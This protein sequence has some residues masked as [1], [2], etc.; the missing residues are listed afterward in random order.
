MSHDEG[1][2]KLSPVER[3]RAQKRAE[4]KLRTPTCLVCGRRSGFI[5]WPC[6]A[7][8]LQKMRDRMTEHV[9]GWARQDIA[10]RRTEMARWADDGGRAG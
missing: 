5:C 7:K 2:M 1:R 4:A 3:E 9:I 10:Q 8:M 6:E